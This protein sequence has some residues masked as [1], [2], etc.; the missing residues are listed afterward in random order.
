MSFDKGD[1]VMIDFDGIESPGR[2]ISEM[3]GWVMAH[4]GID[5]LADYGAISSRLS[6]VSTVCVP[7]T[8]VRHA[9]V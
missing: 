2:V 4:I 7:A 5:V 1:P 9:D 8:R 3:H 6:P